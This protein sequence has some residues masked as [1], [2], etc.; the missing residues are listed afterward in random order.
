MFTGIIEEK[1]QI[2]SIRKGQDSAS[3]HICCQK[4][5]AETKTGDSIAVNGACL[6][7]TSLTP[8]GFS[9]DVMLETLDR[10]ALGALGPGSGVNLERAL[11]F[12]GRLGGH[13]VSGH[14]DGVGRVLR[15]RKEGIARVISI[16]AGSD[17]LAE[18]VMK[19]SVAVDGISL[20]IM[21]LERDFF[22]VSIIPH[23]MSE[24]TLGRAGTGT[25][26][27]LETDLLGKYVRRFLQ[28]QREEKKDIDM[29]FL[30]EQ[31]FL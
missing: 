9:A 11:A 14:V 19:G 15:C 23:T 24:T 10:T 21:E 22:S 4:V 1:G 2:E 27:N 5:L 8:A 18:L 17:L 25:L 26:V 30:A 28:P 12:G 3:L 20:T 13:L 29:N 6:T 7:V 31:G 16:A